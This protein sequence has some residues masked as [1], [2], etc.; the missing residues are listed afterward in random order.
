MG[1]VARWPQGK[2]MPLPQPV[3]RQKEVLY[4]PANGHVVVLGTAGSGKTM[5]H[6]Q[7]VIVM[8]YVSGS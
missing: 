2:P 4:L 3:G 7:I 8:R 6:S 5:L 1:G